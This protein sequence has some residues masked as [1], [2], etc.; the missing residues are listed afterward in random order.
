MTILVQVCV[1]VNDK[2]A[3]WRSNLSLSVC[4]WE[5]WRSQCL[6]FIPEW[7]LSGSDSPMELQWIHKD[8]LFSTVPAHPHERESQTQTLASQNVFHCKYKKRFDLNVLEPFFFS[9]THPLCFILYKIPTFLSAQSKDC[10]WVTLNT[11]FNFKATTPLSWVPQVTWQ[12][13]IHCRTLLFLTMLMGW[14][15]K[16]VAERG[17][18]HYL[19][20]HRRW[21]P[22]LI[23]SFDAERWFPTSFVSCTL[24]ALSDELKS[25]FFDNL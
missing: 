4:P 23:Q 3:C 16:A 2:M 15:S 8:A 19:L 5:T 14:V 12:S 1:G 9:F 24:T 17:N 18:G 10:C 6:D 11:C 13:L 25:P 21:Q 22:T 7:A 20:W